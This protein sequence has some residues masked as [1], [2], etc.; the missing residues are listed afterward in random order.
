MIELF[1][2]ED[3]RLTYEEVEWHRRSREIIQKYALNQEDIR[4]KALKGLDL[5]RT[6][7]LL[8]LG[9]GYGSFLE[10]LV[11]R[12]DP[13]AHI[14]G[15]D[16]INRK[17]RE[18]FMNTLARIGCKG[19]FIQGSADLIR[20]M[21][22]GSF[23]LVIASYSLY[24]FPH[25]IPEIARILRREGLFI[26]ITHSKYSLQE[27]MEHVPESME[28]AGMIPPNDLMIHK[29][30]QAFCLEDGG[31]ALEEYFDEVELIPY[32]NSLVFPV[33]HFGDCA[34][35][36]KNKRH[37][38]FKEASEACPAKLDEVSENCTRALHDRAL[39]QGRILVNKDDGI[40]RCR[41]PVAEKVLK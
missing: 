15:I 25:L 33:E 18:P 3:L 4:E 32:R 37:L 27:I 23:D 13:A 10:K 17:N 19:M 41:L 29:L 11:G 40:F 26:T 14:T 39:I 1:S 24:F 5:S 22:A 7:R 31:A 35:Y 20:D 38:L 6:R 9:C 30:F 21:E 16:V 28:K 34:E 8:D 12:L 2:M 36:I